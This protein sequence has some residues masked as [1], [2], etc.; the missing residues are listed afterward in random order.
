MYCAVHNVDCPYH[1]ES[2]QMVLSLSSSS[3]PEP[4]MC[5]DAVDEVAQF[6]REAEGHMRGP[7]GGLGGAGDFGF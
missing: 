2:D 3:M 4:W 7:G 1:H 5:P 6:E